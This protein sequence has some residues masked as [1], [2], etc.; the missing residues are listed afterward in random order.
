MVNR[1]K[2]GVSRLSIFC[3]AVA[4]CLYAV[5]ATIGLAFESDSFQHDVLWLFM[6]WAGGLVICFFIVWGFIRA[7]GWVVTG[8]IS[9]N[10]PL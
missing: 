6:W 2:E 9:S 3:A 8:F 5:W 1:F 4:T 7:L 10:D